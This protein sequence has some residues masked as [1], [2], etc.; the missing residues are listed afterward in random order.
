M[1]AKREQALVGLFVLVAGTLLVGTLFALS[2]AFGR[3][4]TP[5]HTYFP[6]AGGI[7]PGATVRYAGGPKVGRVEQL[8]I[9]PQNAARIEITFSVQP[10]LPVK[11]DSRVRIMSMSPLG[12]NHIEI[13]PGSPQAGPAPAGSALP[14]DAYLDFNAIT[15]QINAIGPQAQ[16][17]LATLNQRAVE[18]KVTV[19]RVNSLLSDENRANLAAS[20]AN[21]RGMLEENRPR[22]KSTLTHI[23][24]MSQKLEPLLQEFRTTTEQA[25]QTLTHID[26]MIGENRA[27]VRQA[28]IKL[29]KTLA[30]TSELTAQLDRTLNVNSENIDE[31]LENMRHVTENLKQFTDTIKTRPYTLIRASNPREHKPGEKQ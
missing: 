24:E 11:T 13:L 26:A 16:Q 22:V 20:L 31:L 28:V 6:F 21:T 19:E 25:N 29:R 15:S 2:G 23:D 18:L 9:D 8:R 14:S 27:D 30:S 3:A 4:A 5:Y 10:E 17:L 12:E 1:E 7:E